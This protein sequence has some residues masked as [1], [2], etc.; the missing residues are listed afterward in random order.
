[1]QVRLGHLESRRSDGHLRT[2]GVTLLKLGRDDFDGYRT[3]WFSPPLSLSVAARSRQLPD[4]AVGRSVEDA[5]NEIERT[6]FGLASGLD[7]R[8]NLRE[9][10][11]VTRC[12]SSLGRANK[13]LTTSSRR[14]KGLSHFVRINCLS[15]PFPPMSKLSTT[16]YFPGS[17]IRE[18][19]WRETTLGSRP[20]PNSALNHTVQGHIPLPTSPRSLV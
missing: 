10:V 11:V 3:S 14:W 8:D 16:P 19:C 17:S 7:R 12:G 15:R 2:A 1:M 13:T 20:N 4:S 18:V 6:S 5:S 9:V